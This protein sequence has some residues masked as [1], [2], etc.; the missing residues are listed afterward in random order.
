MRR[1]DVVGVPVGGGWVEGVTEEG[2]ERWSLV[3]VC[4]IGEREIDN[5]GFGVCVGVV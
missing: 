5:R 3:G 4:S 1:G 2:G